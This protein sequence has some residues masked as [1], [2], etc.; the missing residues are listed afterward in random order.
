MMRNGSIM[1]FEEWNNEG[2]LLEHRIEWV[3]YDTDCQFDTARQ[4]TQQAIDDGLQF[5]I[6]PLCSEAAIAAA[7][8]AQLEKVLLISPAATHPLVTVDGA[9]Q[10]R[11]T[12]FRAGY[13]YPLQAQAAALFAY[14]TLKANKAALFSSP[15]D[16]YSATLAR[17]FAQQFSGQGGEIVHQTTYTP[18]DVDFTDTLLAL[19]HSEAEVIYLPAPAAV[20]NR[21][22]GQLNEL[23]SSGPSSNPVLL[24]SD[25]WESVE[26]DLSATGGS[27]FTTHFA[28]TD[29][30]PP[31]QTW[32]ETYKSAYAI[33]PNTLAVLGY[34]AATLLITAIQQAGTFD[35]SAVV[36][37]LEQGV[38][39]GVTGQ[40]SFDN[41]HNPIK[42]V[43]V[44]QIKDGRT[45][46]LT[47]VNVLQK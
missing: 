11:R 16:N 28:P 35:T 7:Q 8:T 25:S 37:A 9:G 10:T 29:Q 19:R 41:Q 42:P 47:S 24:G 6:G 39:R 40:I 13:A 2:G 44:V 4:V 22:A 5:I 23:G 38:F 45:I 20:V 27:Y 18:G 14:Q 3:V 21:V 34:D 17:L 12:I 32:T 46:F 1:A 15:G 26:L 31:V 30:R 33:E 43:P 36:K